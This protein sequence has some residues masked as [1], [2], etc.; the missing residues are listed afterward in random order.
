LNTP[1]PVQVF[2][3]GKIR[4]PSGC[5]EKLIKAPLHW[6]SSVESCEIGSNDVDIE[7]SLKYSAG[8]LFQSFLSVESL[9]LGTHPITHL[10]NG[11]SKSKLFSS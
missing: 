5:T 8:N 9:L 3:E 2:I 7:I 10:H 4:N 1:P 11:V 6:M